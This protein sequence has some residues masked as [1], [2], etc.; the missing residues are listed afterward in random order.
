M[1][2]IYL[3]AAWVAGVYLG[4]KTA[5]PISIIS[6]GLLPV[7][8]IP[9]LKRYKRY[10]LLASFCLLVSLG[11]SLRFQSSLPTIDEQHLQFY[12]NKGIVEI[13]GM[14]CQ[15]PEIRNA[16][17]I[18]QLSAL[19]LQIDSTKKKVSGK[20]LVRV[21]KYH[22]YHYGDILKLIG[23]LETPPQLDDFDYGAYLARQGI[24]SCINYPK[25]E[26][27]DT[28]KGFRPLAWVYSLR[29]RLA[30]N[31]SLTL[32]EPQASLA[33]A[34]FLGL[35]GNVP[36]ELRRTF[37]Q[38]GTAHL[39]AISGLHLS[40]VM[41]IFISAGIWLIGRRYYIYIWLAF[42][43]IWLYALITGM[44]PPV[45]RGAIMGSLFLIAE[46]LGRQ[47]SASTALAFAAA[48]MVGI[49]PQIL[50]DASFQLTFLG[51]AG[52]VF[53]C[54]YLQAWGRKGIAATIGREGTTTSLCYVVA[55]S[56]AVTLAAILTTCPV[57]AYY[58]GIVSFVGL[59]ATFFT[60]LAL[61]GIIVTAALTSTAGLVALQLA[62]I[63]SWV[64][65]LF[66]SYFI[67]V[68][69]AFDA[70]PLAS[71]RLGNVHIW[72]I[73]MYYA[74]LLAVIVTV[75]HH[76]QL[77]SL[78]SKTGF[79]IGYA[80]NQT[81][82]RASK[83]PKKW[84]TLPVLIAATLVWIAALNMPGDKLH[85]SILNVG[86]GDAI[87]IQTPYRQDI[88][89]DGGP[90]P[91][92]IRLELGK[93]LPFWDKTIE[94]M[95]LTQPQA[96][97]IT[98]LIEVVQKY[99][100][101]QVI[102]PGMTYSSTSYQRW[103]SLI[104]DRKIRHEIAHAG[105]E[106]NLGNEIKLEVLHPPMPLLQ[107][108]SN[109]VDNNCLVLRLSWNKVSFLFTADIGQEAEQH[110]V[111]QRANIKST[112][113][114][115]AHHGSQTSTSEEFLSVVNPKVAVIPVAADNIFNLPDTKVVN[116]LTKLLENR[117]YLTSTHGTVEFITDGERLWMK[118]DKQQKT[119]LSLP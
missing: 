10:L 86:Q 82:D 32:P 16:T 71:L 84:F 33:Q 115:V 38:T 92:A 24:Y 54:P 9:F 29:N 104:N 67:L 103:L 46:Y 41:G 13:N 105:Q 22:E 35:R 68:V 69:Q 102:E 101:S 20:A 61:P 28:G 51:M 112:V 37:S 1:T 5:L 113:L 109:D 94:L 64:A 43:G 18:F 93:K 26:I 97:H 111:A 65:W 72:Q 76:R 90:S 108:T 75:N 96:D 117:V 100:V 53:I 62:Q 89:I 73:W 40:I 58:F 31:L 19:E 119:W 23:R 83:L 48:V 88:L 27:L 4:S 25:I 14:V 85:V 52:L 118:Y 17:A 66:L 70:I 34:I 59:P 114:K 116:R 6:L 15:E 79:K 99:K 47:R 80:L 45:V 56:F 60:L 63:L 74:A 36:P 3:S 7:C 77:A 49:E 87:L 95:V 2:L 12:N 50:W 78:F 42:F 55:D 81:A 30:E 39:L 44:R 57:I 11:G 106:V 98:G 8:L 91:R 107:G 110:L 21:P